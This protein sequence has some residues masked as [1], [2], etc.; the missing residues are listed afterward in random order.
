MMIHCFCQEGLL[1]EANELCVKMEANDC[2]PD[3]VTYNTL[4]RG[5]F[6]NKKY[7][8]AS[9]LIDQMRARCFSKDASTTVMLRD[10]LASEKQDPSIIAL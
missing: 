9:V 8:E 2:L 10:L 1:D 7:N 5:C 3:D 6:H 4:I